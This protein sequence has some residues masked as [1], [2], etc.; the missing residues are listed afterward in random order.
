MYTDEE[1]MVE[2]F[3]QQELIQLTDRSGATGEIVAAVLDRAIADAQEEIDSYLRAAGYTVP[4]DPVPGIVTRIASDIARYHLYDDQAT[5]EVRN[6]YKD[7]IRF[8]ER[9]ASGDVQIGVQPGDGVGR[10]QV[11]APERVFTRDDLR[12]YG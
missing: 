4:L 11:S 8:L 2:R 7:Q 3:G 6:R 9:V 10:P 1:A 12:D 5:E